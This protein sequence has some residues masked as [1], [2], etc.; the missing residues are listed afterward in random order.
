MVVRHFIFDLD[1]TLYPA[2]ARMDAGITRRMIEFAARVT[3]VSIEETM[4]L[5]Q[6]ALRKYSTTGDWLRYE[7]GQE[8]YEAYFAAVHP[9]S[10]LEELDFDPQLRPFLQSL[11]Q[12]KVIL[13]NAPL[14]H[15]I[16]VLD[17]M[18]VS[19]LFDG[20]SDIRSNRLRGKPSPAAFAQALEMC[21]GTVEDTLFLDDLKK[22]VDGYNAIGGKG[23]LVN[24]HLND[25]FVIE[26]GGEI[27]LKSVYQITKL[28]PKTIDL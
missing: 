2:T 19:D 1:N 23:I 28:L 26:K 11:P 18:R 4:R 9:E 16:R 20:I 14:E 12:S 6:A 5:R 17:F 27:I 7:Y 3:G 10:E 22:Y 21:G 24:A 25:G 15:A 13:T 8:D